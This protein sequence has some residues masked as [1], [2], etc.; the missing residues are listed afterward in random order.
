MS[1]TDTAKLAIELGKKGMY[2]ELQEKIMQLREEALE[3]QEENQKLKTEN[4][5]LK[6]KTELREKVEYRRKVYYL[7]GD[8]I[9]YCPYCY[10]TKKL[11]IHLNLFGADNPSGSRYD[12]QEC[13]IRYHVKGDGDFIFLIGRSK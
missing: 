12:C 13:R 8:E 11:L 1:I 3:L 6:K 5:E 4:L 10:E 9:P 7:E 2:V